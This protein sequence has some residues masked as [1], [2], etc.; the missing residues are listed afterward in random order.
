LDVRAPSPRRLAL[1][2][3]LA[4]IDRL[5]DEALASG[6]LAMLDEAD[7]RE[8]HARHEFSAQEGTG[9]DTDD[10]IAR[11][12]FD[13]GYGRLTAAQARGEA[14]PLAEME[15]LPEEWGPGY[16]RLTATER[17][18]RNEA[19]RLERTAEE[20]PTTEGP[21]DDGATSTEPPAEVEPVEVT[22]GQETNSISTP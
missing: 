13:H 20:P 19:R 10:S 6:D 18:A 17:H 15:E 4:E 1:R 12:P 21:L 3:R 8:R 22:E 11:G 9:E 5:R 2:R 14:G 16:G 7:R